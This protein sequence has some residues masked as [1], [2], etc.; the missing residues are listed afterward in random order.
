[1]PVGN[2]VHQRSFSS[3]TVLR[4]FM[5]LY[6]GSETVPANTMYAK[7]VKNNIS[8]VKKN[9]RHAELIQLSSELFCSLFFVLFHRTFTPA[10]YAV[11]FLSLQLSC[12]DRYTIRSWST[13]QSVDTGFRSA[14]ADAIPHSRNI[15]KPNTGIRLDE[16]TCFNTST[17]PMF[18]KAPSW[19]P[20]V[21]A[22][23]FCSADYNSRYDI[24]NASA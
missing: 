21:I 6:F 16:E 20:K 13:G 12:L 11:F 7:L 15:L 2:G 19:S 9:E 22:L 3:L 24:S 8:G 5:T 18:V 1:M 17:G 23:S 4:T 10:E 14:T